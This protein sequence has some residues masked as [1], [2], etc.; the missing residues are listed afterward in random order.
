M[1]LLGIIIAVLGLS[2]LIF[3]HELGHYVMAK[4][5]GMK[6]E[7]F[8]IGMGKPI[9][10]WKQNGV[11]W[12]ICYLL[13]GGYVRIAG[14]EGEKGKEPYQI[15][16]G[17]YSKKPVQRLLVAGAGPFVNIVFAFFLFFIVYASGGQM[18]QFSEHTNLIG[19]LDK[20]SAIAEL[21]ITPGDKIVSVDGKTYKSFKDLL[22]AGMLKNKQNVNVVFEK[23]NNERVEARVPLYSPDEGSVFFAAPSE[24]KTTGVLGAAN[25][26]IF[27]GF[28]EGQEEFAP[29]KGAGLVKGDRVVY[30]DGETI[31]SRA[32]LVSVVSKDIAL[33]T[34]LRDGKK[35][36][37]QVPRVAL[38]DVKLSSVQKNDFIDT[39]RDIEFDGALSSLHFIPYLVSGALDVE[40][41]LP[42]IEEENRSL[43]APLKKGD[44]ILAVA[45]QKVS[46]AKDFFEAVSKRRCVIMAAA[47]QGERLSF[48]QADKA[49]V[50][51]LFADSIV[52][53]ENSFG[54]E[55]KASSLKMFTAEP[56]KFGA[57]LEKA[58]PEAM[59]QIKTKYGNEK[60]ASFMDRNVLFVGLKMKDKQ[61]VYNPPPL[62]CA[63][64]IID[65][66]AFSFKGLFTGSLSPKH[67]SGP[68]GMVKIVHDGS[69]G[70][71]VT[72]LYWLGLIS[73]NLGLMNLL[74]LPVLDGGHICFTV[75]E[76]VT[77][78]R[79]KA[80]TMQKMMV[81][82]VFLLVAFFAYVT[83]YDVMKV[84]G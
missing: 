12:Q 35:I 74:P 39:K 20:G 26:E 62:T 82:F 7:V 54:G 45:G 16:G 17:F 55:Q 10:S 83:I 27:N 5:A 9:I 59:D 84:F 72:G 37:V 80:K 38:G 29:L 48:E 77:R 25:Y 51:G 63:G 11:K 81:P 1:S 70:S 57:F 3:I 53:M 23:K 4:R 14:M 33:V 68:V 6:I 44:K 60:A 34:V 30:V 79:I 71:V 19:S 2:F 49:F 31:Y 65:E 46:S 50:S 67:M 58:S 40:E 41:A 47:E 13:F 78:K 69:K 28:E 75:Y 15:K 36:H 52:E 8:S 61:V 66:M 18:K 64:D 24:W 42:M 32:D 76:M 56:I 73:L 43:P 21:G 22:L